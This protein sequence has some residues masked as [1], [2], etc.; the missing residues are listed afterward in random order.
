[1]KWQRVKKH[2]N[3]HEAETIAHHIKERKWPQIGKQGFLHIE[4]NIIRD[5]LKIMQMIA[6]SRKIDRFD[7]LLLV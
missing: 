4:M 3:I 6:M 7:V 1:M 5:A 2:N